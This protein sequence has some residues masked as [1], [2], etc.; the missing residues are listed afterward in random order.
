MKFRVHRSTIIVAFF[1]LATCHSPLAT[2][3]G[4][5]IIDSIPI[6]PRYTYNPTKAMWSFQQDN[7]ATG[8]Q[9]DFLD[10]NGVPKCWADADGQL[11]CVG[12]I[13]ASA[14]TMQ[15]NG[16]F[17]GTEPI[18]NFI[19]GAG[20]ALT[21][22]N[23]PG[24]T[25]VDLTIA[26]C[27][28]VQNDGTEVGCEPEI[29]FIPGNNISY[30][31]TDDS[32][33]GRT[34]V[35]IDGCDTCGG[36][37]AAPDKTDYLIPGCENDVYYSSGMDNTP[38]DSYSTR[39]L[40]TIPLD[41]THCFITYG[42]DNT[43]DGFAEIKQ[44][45]DEY[46]S[47]T[48][49]S[50][51][52]GAN[53]RF[54]PVANVRAWFGCTDALSTAFA[55]QDDPTSGT[56]Q[57]AMFRYSAG[58]GGG[59]DPGAGDTHWMAALQVSANPPAGEPMTLVDTGVTPDTSIHYFEVSYSSANNLVTWKIDGASVATQAATFIYGSSLN[60][61]LSITSLDTI[62]KTFEFYIFKITSFF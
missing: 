22:V 30:T 8:H 49:T 27:T 61:Y 18:F 44:G 15:R 4:Q 3:R 11:T 39:V 58:T 62:P 34:N 5:E 59:A 20:I 13:I 23:D 9:V 55:T 29:N 16:I 12:G 46:V 50:W 6:H 52:C 14:E 42:T 10:K 41:G 43:L 1:L 31:I 53:I 51:T 21:A 7:A 40:A 28:S 54:D 17:V 24:N 48:A 57:F 37:A 47:Y 56:N 2:V 36:A 60:P 38:I 19:E 35:R 26:S 33:N 25:R 32:G 45:M